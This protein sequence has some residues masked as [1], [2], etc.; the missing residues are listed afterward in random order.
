MVSKN[1]LQQL[2][3]KELFNKRTEWLVM[4][5]VPDAQKITILMLSLSRQM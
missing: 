2:I 3:D 4:I 1:M 5:K